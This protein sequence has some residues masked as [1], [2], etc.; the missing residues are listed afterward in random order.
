MKT[1][2]I[3][4]SLFLTTIFSYSQKKVSYYLELKSGIDLGEVQTT[5]NPS[6]NTL[7]VNTES[8]NFNSFINNAGHL[9]F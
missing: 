2:L 5:A 3:F 8:V 1:Y 9:L 7:T 4:L 6:T